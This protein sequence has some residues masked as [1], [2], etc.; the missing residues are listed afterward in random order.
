[1][2]KKLLV[3]DQE[4]YYLLVAFLQATGLILYCSLVGII[5][6]KGNVW[7]PN[8][9]PYLGPLL[10]LVVFVASALICSLIVFTYPVVKFFETKNI[11]DSLKIVLYTSIWLFFYIIFFLLVVLIF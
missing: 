9:N 2:A 4:E 8:M 5:F 1:M 11:L 10:M 7:F 3:K 6:W